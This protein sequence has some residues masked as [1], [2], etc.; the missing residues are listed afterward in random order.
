MERTL[1]FKIAT[2]CVETAS[3][4]WNV[5]S[6][7]SSLRN[8]FGICVGANL[9]FYQSGI[10]FLT[11][12]FNYDAI[13]QA[14][15]QAATELLV[16]IDFHGEWDGFTSNVLLINEREIKWKPQAQEL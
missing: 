6:N 8:L 4:N 15:W 14:M 9:L 3:D 5:S 12:I 16:F 2:P 1:S 10:D 7:K 13:I 11:L